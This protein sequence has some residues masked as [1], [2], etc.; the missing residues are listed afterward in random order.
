MESPKVK[1]EES[2][3]RV[4]QEEFDKQYFRNIVSQL[5]SEKAAGK[6]IYPPGPLLFNAFEKTPF[7]NVKVVILG[8]D[9]YHN[10]GQAMGLCFSVPKGIKTPASLVNIYKELKSDLGCEIPGHGDLS[11]WA[12]QGV[13]LLNAMLSVE[14]NLAGSH[15][16]FGWQ[17]F[18]DRVIT[19][20]SEQKSGL[21]FLLWGNFARNKRTLIDSKKHLILESAHPSP[22]AGNAFQGNKHFSKTNEYLI[23]QG[24]SPINWQII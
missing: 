16:N 14:Q 19:L 5:K 17:D 13:F 15:K 22:L 18:T 21:V 20:L 6:I 2:W 9:P 11:A 8:Q 7:D 10:P 24:K 23:T 3:Y 4:L 1:I 12:E